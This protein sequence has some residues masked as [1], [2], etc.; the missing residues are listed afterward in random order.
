MYIY[1][2]MSCELSAACAPPPRQK[3]TSK[4]PVFRP[5]I[6]ARKNDHIAGEC[7]GGEWNLRC[8]RRIIIKSYFIRFLYSLCLLKIHK[9]LYS[10]FKINKLTSCCKFVERLRFTFVLAVLLINKIRYLYWDKTK[11][12]ALKTVSVASALKLILKIHSKKI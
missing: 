2:L 11:Y 9:N 12:Y 3:A 4:R 1:G 8:W 6:Q 10:R 5:T 7:S